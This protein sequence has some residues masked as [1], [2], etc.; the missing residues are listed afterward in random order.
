M[1]RQ[2]ALSEGPKLEMKQYLQ[3]AENELVTRTF[4]GGGQ[5]SRPSEVSA[6]PGSF[7]VLGRCLC[8]IQGVMGSHQA[9]MWDSRMIQLMLSKS[10][11]LGKSCDTS[12]LLFFSSVKCG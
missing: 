1:G 11:T 12:E 10:V 2:T 9:L 6:G 5:C 4:R 7:E 3:G 8:F